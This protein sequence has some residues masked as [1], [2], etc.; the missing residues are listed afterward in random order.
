MFDACIV[1]TKRL[2]GDDDTTWAFADGCR[3]GPCT[4]ARNSKAGTKNKTTGTSP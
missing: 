4:V 3:R 2:G 1:A